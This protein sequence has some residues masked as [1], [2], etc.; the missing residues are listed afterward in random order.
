MNQKIRIFDVTRL[1]LSARKKMEGKTAPL[2][3]IKTDPLDSLSG[4]FPVLPA[5]TTKRCGQ[6]FPHDLGNTTLDQMLIPYRT[7]ALVAKLV[8]I[9]MTVRAQ[10]TTL[11]TRC[12]TEHLTVVDGTL[13]VVHGDT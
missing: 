9:F 1:P 2:H 4:Y 8:P 5:A 7:A 13:G 6:V 11:G 10:L 12:L 3:R